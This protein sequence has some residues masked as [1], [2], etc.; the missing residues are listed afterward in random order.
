MTTHVFTSAAMNYLP[1]VRLLCESIRRYHPEFVLH[2]AL[3]D[4]APDVEEKLG[5]LVDDVIRIKDL[6]IPNERSWIFRHS[7]V[8]LCTALKPFVARHLMRQ[9]CGENI[10]YF[11][12]DIVLF[13]RLDD[14]LDELESAS[15][16]LT[17]HLTVPEVTLEGIRDLEVLVLLH[18]VFNLGFI[19]IRNDSNGQTFANWWQQRNYYFCVNDLDAGLFTDQKWINFVPIFFEG[20][21]ILKDTRHNVAPWNLS[22]RRLEGSLAEGFVVDGKPMGFYHFSGVDSGDHRSMVQKYACNN[23]AITELS[24]WYE[25]SAVSEGSVCTTRWAYG[26][27]SNG[28]PI[29]RAHRIV[30]R[31][32]V[33]LQSQYPDPFDNDTRSSYYV[34]FKRH[35][36][37]EYPT[38]IDRSPRRRALSSLCGLAWRYSLLLATDPLYGGEV[39]RKGWRLLRAEGYRGVQERLFSRLTGYK[40]GRSIGDRRLILGV[41]SDAGPADRPSQPLSELGISSARHKV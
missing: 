26:V 11:D 31:T 5:S 7:V 35:A 20:V 3:A 36:A 41:G 4:V 28:A 6:Q 24:N 12:P 34:W 22:T 15:V 14:L 8:E 10:L 37:L 38:L 39:L 23:A 17:P 9:G 40:R 16:V 29:T 13:S 30:Y 19:G 2:L 25:R 32:R 1:K 21:K 18:G 27:F 33:D